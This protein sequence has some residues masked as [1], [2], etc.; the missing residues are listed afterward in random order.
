MK[1]VL[2][3]DI[4][5]SSLKGGIINQTGDLAAWNRIGML[6]MGNADLRRW[7][8]IIWRQALRFFTDG[9]DYRGTISAVVISGNGPTVVPLPS[10]GS[11]P[12]EAFLWLDDRSEESIGTASFYLPKVLWIKRHRPRLYEKTRRF[13]GCP[14]FLSYLLCGEIC[15]FSPTA[16]FDPLI[17]REED[18]HGNGLDPEKFA[19]I[20][21]TAALIGRITAEGSALSGLPEGIAVYAGGPD[22]MSAYLGTAGVKPGRTCDRAGTSEGI[23][24]CSPS[25]VECYSLR[26]T[27]H[28]V[29][30]LYN[31][32]GILDSTGRVFEWFR[33]ITNQNHV[34]YEEMLSEINSSS[35]GRH[36][37]FFFPSIHQRETWQ[38]RRGIFFELEPWHTPV[39][40][41]R[42]VV[43]AIGFGIRQVI[44][45]LYENGC[46]VESLK[47]S[48]GQGRNA[49]WN[50]MKADLTDTPVEV[51][52]IIDGEITGNGCIGFTG[53]GLYSGLDEA[54][55]S[56]VKM[57]ACYEPRPGDR[58]LLAERY[59]LYRERCDHVIE[60]IASF[61]DTGR[62]YL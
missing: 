60:A 48:G 16:E 51:P 8:P 36:T 11:F 50:Q 42:G 23:N 62:L 59:M 13:L 15:M 56:I 19:P 37:P 28:A 17:W 6:E 20:V 46:K 5:T 61:P 3:I 57:R 53:M 52:S 38:F 22:Y 44:E 47:V 43:E 35:A 27:P 58:D 9:L 24:F 14:E 40:M 45:T 39:D 30:G 7:D 21:R 32:A 26:T 55:E 2:A 10:D 1:T 41:G 25:P 33:G 54:A 29:A 34:N 49:V 31:V 12:R 18:L 4:G